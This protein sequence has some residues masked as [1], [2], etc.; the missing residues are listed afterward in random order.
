MS[1]NVCTDASIFQSLIVYLPNY[2]PTGVT[3]T[4]TGQLVYMNNETSLFLDTAVDIATRGRSGNSTEW[5]TCLA[6][7][8]VERTRGREGV[9]RTPT[10]NTCFQQYC[11]DGT[12]AGASSNNGTSTGGSDSTGGLGNGTGTGT[13]SGSNGTSNGGSGGAQPVSAAVQIHGRGMQIVGALV[14]V[15]LALI[16]M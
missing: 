9:D 3:N 5:T 14:A 12:E 7:A 2:D 13:G 4:S 15:G 1:S 8:V 11:W 16:A 6:C 10:C